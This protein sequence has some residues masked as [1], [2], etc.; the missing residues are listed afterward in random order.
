MKSKV[1]GVAAVVAGSE[2]SNF[3]HDKGGRHR[4]WSMLKKYAKRA[5]MP[6]RANSES[7]TTRMVQVCLAEGG[8][9]NGLHPGTSECNVTR[10]YASLARVPDGGGSRVGLQTATTGRS[11][12]LSAIQESGDSAERDN[13]A[14]GPG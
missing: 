7:A 4:F 6:S 9:R 12:L 14:G 1:A 5:P 13:S 10:L 3:G 11:L 8:P 2:R